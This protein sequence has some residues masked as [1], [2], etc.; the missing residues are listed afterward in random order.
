MCSQN[1]TRNARY[2][3]SDF[4]DK[5][6][7]WISHQDITQY[8]H[9]NIKQR[10]PSAWFKTVKA[11]LNQED[12]ENHLKRRISDYVYN[13]GLGN[14]EHPLNELFAHASQTHY[15][16]NPHIMRKLKEVADKENEQIYTSCISVEQEKEIA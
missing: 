9:C 16:N 6:G 3:I 5:K 8:V 14:Y 10:F 2:I 12:L 11:F 1:K 13:D 7:D 4:F 15:K